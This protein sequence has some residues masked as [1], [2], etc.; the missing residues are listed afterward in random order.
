VA[1][2]SKQ[3]DAVEVEAV[4]EEEELS[5]FD[6]PGAERAPLDVRDIP[7]EDIAEL[8][9]IR[10]NYHGIE[11]LAE[12]MHLEGQLQPCLVRPAAADA[13]HG[14][15]FEMI[16]GYRRKRA[17]EMLNE[18][19]LE[20]WTSLRCE[21]RPVEDGEELSKVI[22]ENFQREAPSPVAEAKAMKTLKF[23]TDPPMT[24]TE[25]ARR[26]GCDPSQISHRL[27]LLKLG[28]PSAAPQPALG[29]GAEDDTTEE[30][31]AEAAEH[32]QLEKVMSSAPEPSPAAG[33]DAEV[34]ELVE[35]EAV[36]DT[37]PA[38]DILDMVDKG[39]IS[40]SAAEVIASLDNREDQEKLA[41]LVKRHDW[42]VKKTAAWARNVKKHELD[43]GAAEMG[44][45]EMLTMSDPVELLHLHPRP[46]LTEADIA[47]VTLYALLRNAMDRE[48]IEYLDEEMGVPFNAFW[49]YVSDL[50]DDQVKELTTR[51]SLRYIAAAHRFH[52]LEPSLKDQLGTAEKYSFDDASDLDLPQP[53][54]DDRAL[55]L[56]EQ[57]LD[58]DDDE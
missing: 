27:G 1:D 17:V 44:P 46:D 25:I 12:T 15:P 20:A 50:N 47:R 24:N 28:M 35:G 58:W 5:A 56:A 11:G 6:L 39:E 8:P 18:R 37:G 3:E 26:L 49:D 38:V 30:T 14:R 23:S 48:I 41:V 19:G 7:L 55:P 29:P 33:E 22:V 52:D 43:E 21:V 45:I 36:E 42:G 54:A 2:E 9:N 31:P 40:A 13:E 57:N 16:F 53:V 51:I 10:Q 34:P 4:E 32:D